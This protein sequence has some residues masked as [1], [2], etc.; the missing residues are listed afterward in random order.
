MLL[1]FNEADG[2]II[3]PWIMESKRFFLAVVVV[4]RELVLR[5]AFLHAPE[6][7]SRH[8]PD[9]P[10]RPSCSEGWGGHAFRLLS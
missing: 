2:R 3:L 9:V 7:F 6:P 5:E 4:E 8:F 1:R 10:A